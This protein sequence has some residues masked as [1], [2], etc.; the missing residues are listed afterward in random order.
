MTS[1]FRVIRPDSSLGGCACYV[2]VVMSG[3]MSRVS[4]LWMEDVRECDRCEEG[5]L[6]L[7][8]H[9]LENRYCCLAIDM[10]FLD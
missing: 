5:R 7:I 4:S 6:L 9:L 8:L 3:L 1:R 2:E 10:M